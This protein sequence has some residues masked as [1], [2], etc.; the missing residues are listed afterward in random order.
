MRTTKIM[1][2]TI[3]ARRFSTCNIEHNQQKPDAHSEQHFG[4]PY[5]DRFVK[6]I[7]KCGLWALGL[8]ALVILIPTG[9]GWKG[10]NDT[11]KKIK[12]TNEISHSNLSNEKIQEVYNNMSKL[13]KSKAIKYGQAVIDS[14]NGVKVIPAKML[15]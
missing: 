14:I 5:T 13:T 7:V 1:A 6:R 11:E 10:L 4:G 12:V 15:K 2:S 9:L 3:Q 8:S